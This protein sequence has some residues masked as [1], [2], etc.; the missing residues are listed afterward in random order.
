MSKE[1]KVKS[2]A[3]NCITQDDEHVGLINVTA[4]AETDVDHEI[5]EVKCEKTRMQYLG[6]HSTEV[7]MAINMRKCR[8][9]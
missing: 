9:F 6:A 3:E 1:R 8:C 4:E 2:S 7:N 5:V